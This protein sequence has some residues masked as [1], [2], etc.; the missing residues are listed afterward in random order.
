MKSDT[1]W[2]CLMISREHMEESPTNSVESILMEAF[3]TVFN[4]IIFSMPV[5][6]TAPTPHILLIENY[7]PQQEQV[8][9]SV[10]QES[11]TTEMPQVCG[12]LALQGT[13]NNIMYL[14]DG[15]SACPTILPV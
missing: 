13:L 9:T 6:H 4:A 8:P 7:L 14:R 5:M 12:R 3:L 2:G 10:A 15:F 1:I 11:W